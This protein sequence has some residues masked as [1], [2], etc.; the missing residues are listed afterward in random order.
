MTQSQLGPRVRALRETLSLTQ[1]QLAERAGI[2]H[3]HLSMIERGDR[4]P[5]VETLM[6]LAKALGIAVS[7]LLLDANEPGESSGQ[8]P[9]L[10]LMTYLGTLRLTPGDVNRLVA[11][12]KAMF[13]GR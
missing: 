2:S 7:Q 12:A 13:D 3:S 6:S 1:E 4:T 5:H 8:S 11:I 9:D 10:Q